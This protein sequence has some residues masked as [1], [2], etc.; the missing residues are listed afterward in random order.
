MKKYNF[1]YDE[2]EHSR[3]INHKTITADNYFDSFIAVIVGWSSEDEADLHRRYAEFEEKYKHR[4]SKG[5]LK[6]STIRQSQLKNGFASLNNDNICL[7]KDFLSLF[8]EKTLV[9]YAIIS[10]VEFI[11]NQLLKDYKNS[12]F[13][14]MDAMKYS[15]TK[16]LVLYQPKEIIEGL[17]ENTEELVAL[18][19]NFFIA[20]INKNKANELLK[21]KEIEQFCQ[22][23]MF[24]DD[25]ST[26]RTIDWNYDISFV[27]FKKY[28]AE[29][30]I[31]NYSLTIDKEGE[32]G[33]TAKAAERV[34]L[35]AIEEVDSLNSFGIRMA[36][37]L[38]GV[39][40]KLVKALHNDL[41]YTLLE[42]QVHKKIL[43]K[44]WFMIN[45]QQF[46][47]Y[48]R[49]HNVVVELNK[50]WYKAF[51]GRY[52]D[53]LIALIAFLEFI[54]HFEKAEALKSDIDMQGEYF[55]TYACKSL[56][57]YYERMRSK[58]SI[59]PVSDTSKEYFLNQSGAKVYYDLNQQPQLEFKNSRLV[60][61]VLAIG[62]SREM[63]PLATVAEAKE[64]KC[65][66]LPIDLAEWA[67]TLV[68]FANMGENM[69]PSKVMFSQTKDGCYA[70]IL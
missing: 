19:K 30:A 36:D 53:D 42:G 46:A 48:K 17:Y 59:D 49:M 65:Y 32:N 4:Q 26:I 40:S 64:I 25:V 61:D 15:I 56:S 18:L 34:G 70:D 38:A 14:D 35:C 12:L 13:V 1:Y 69:F 52:S 50:A 39:I 31:G 28:L 62:F 63:I 58:L 47:L 2:S 10:K 41:H 67:M 55:N 51:A 66:R 33:N 60:C 37:M 54:S 68:E 20:Q 29:K 43:N 45:E 9:Y 27:G 11:I 22:I 57:N 5:E 21:Q 23:L 6:S 8:D 24:L 44:S 3:K 16:A 7:L